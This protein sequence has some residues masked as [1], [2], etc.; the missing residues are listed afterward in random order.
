MSPST[1]P[2]A[3]REG[4]EAALSRRT[5]RSVEILGV[6]SVTG[7]CIHETARLST[8]LQEDFFSQMGPGLPIGRLCG[9][10]RWPECPT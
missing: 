2:S 5:A 9:G 1:L 8:N 3:L 4:V 6:E 10:G 7:G